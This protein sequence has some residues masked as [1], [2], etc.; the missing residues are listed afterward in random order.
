MRV[1]SVN[2]VRF[3]DKFQKLVFVNENTF[4]GCVFVVKSNSVES[5]FS[6]ID[7]V[8][9]LRRFAFDYFLYKFGA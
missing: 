9:F 3:P 6:R 8:G 5:V 1:G 2:A 4:F 7:K